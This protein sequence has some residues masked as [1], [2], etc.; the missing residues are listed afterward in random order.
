MAGFVARLAGGRQVGGG[1][2]VVDCCGGVGGGERGGGGKRGGGEGLDWAGVRGDAEFWEG[3]WGEGEGW[4]KWGSWVFSKP[5]GGGS[6]VRRVGRGTGGG[7][8]GEIRRGRIGV[9]GS[10]NR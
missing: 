8:G 3:V 4:Q 9:C 5:S 1:V 6:L 10:G 7:E 2:G